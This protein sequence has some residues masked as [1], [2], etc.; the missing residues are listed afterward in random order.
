MSI[1]DIPWIRDIYKDFYFSEVATTYMCGGG[2][3]KKKAAELL[4]SNYKLPE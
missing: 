1:N 3:K 2:N 4:I